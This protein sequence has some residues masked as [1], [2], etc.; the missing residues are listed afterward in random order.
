M[1][2]IRTQRG[3]AL[4]NVRKAPLMLTSR[5]PPAQTFHQWF[6]GKNNVGTLWRT[7]SWDVAGSSQGAEGTC[8]EI[9]CFNYSLRYPRKQSHVHHWFTLPLLAIEVWP[10]NSSVPQCP[11][12]S[13]PGFLTAQPRSS[14]CCSQRP[15]RSSI[16]YRVQKVG[17][18]E[19]F[20][21]L[22]HPPLEH[23]QAGLC[24]V[25]RWRA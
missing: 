23:P 3:S 16:T 11:L 5:P 4:D 15:A 12:I 10:M 18:G 9:N 22:H 20:G 13:Q 2:E 19:L 17:C 21:L 7:W 14:Q 24:P 6:G 25:Q 1:Q 8:N